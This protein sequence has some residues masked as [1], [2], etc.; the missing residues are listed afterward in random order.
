MRFS[1]REYLPDVEVFARHSYQDNVPFLARNFGTFGVHVGY[2][3]FDGGKKRATVR[4]H[5]SQLAQARENLARITEE[6][7]LRVQTAYNKL[8]RSRQMVRVSEELLASR[9]EARRVLLREVREGAALASQ[10]D[11]AATHE[12]DAR[13]TLL[14]S[15]L[16]LVEAQDEM[17]EAMGVRPE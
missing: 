7:E 5:S 11:N 10:L 16:Q 17:T 6:V 12:L 9:T 2:D 13:T 14:Q 8:E 15:Q 1:K 3:I 4:E